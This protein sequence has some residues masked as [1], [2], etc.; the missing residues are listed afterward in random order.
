MTDNE[1]IAEFMGIPQMHD[2]KGV[3]WDIQ[4]TGK[5]IFGVRPD[6]LRYHS[7]WD[8]LMPV[9]EKIESLQFKVDIYF[10]GCSITDRG[11]QNTTWPDGKPICHGL[12]DSKIEGA[13]QA[14][15]EFI[16]WHNHKTL[17]EPSDRRSTG[18]AETSGK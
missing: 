9:V 4:R 2:Y 8:W 14:V 6:E 13:Y 7:S 1:L 10:C 11:G 18:S 12:G 15:V 5:Q 17:G 16:K 3:M